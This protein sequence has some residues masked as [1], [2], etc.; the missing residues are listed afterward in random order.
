MSKADIEARTAEIL[1]SVECRICMDV[2]MTV[3]EVDGG[4]R[5]ARNCQCR[6]TKIRK[7]RF[8][9]AVALTP[10]TFRENHKVYDGLR[11]IE[12]R[13]QTHPKQPEV[14]ERLLKRIVTHPNQSYFFFGRTGAHKT[15]FAWALVQE[16]ARLGKIVGGNTGKSL[17]DSLRNYA[18]HGTIPRDQSFYSLEQLE[19]SAERF[20]VLIDDI[21][22]ILIS[23]YTFALLWDLLDKVQAY[24]Q[25]LIITSNRSIDDLIEDWNERDRDG[26]A[27][28]ANFSQKLARRLKETCLD[29]D[30]S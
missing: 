28:A 5:R 7:A 16:A 17:I 11:M 19:T 9:K 27:N 30:L 26:R 4:G 20:C 14:L 15:T 22:G 10:R 3:E 1:A 12:P 13:P 2:G 29:I 6:T 8:D 23:E 21:D 24:Q 25:Q 18:I